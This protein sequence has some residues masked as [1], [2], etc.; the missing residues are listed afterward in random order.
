MDDWD[1]A[2]LY[3]A[4]VSDRQS[5]K[6]EYLVLPSGSCCYQIERTDRQRQQ[7]V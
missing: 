6:L 3:T 1:R 7:V 4:L 5:N 2:E